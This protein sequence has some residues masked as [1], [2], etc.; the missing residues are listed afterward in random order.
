MDRCEGTSA[1][2]LAEQALCLNHFLVQCY[3]EL[4]RI[5]PRGRKSLR[6]A[7]QARKFVDECSNQALNICL[8][9]ESLSNLEK[10]QL[11]DI[12]LWAGEVY[13]LVRPSSRSVFGELLHPANPGACAWRPPS[14]DPGRRARKHDQNK[15]SFPASPAAMR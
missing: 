4:D 9:S 11:L 10:G 14:A 8:Q 5:D 15:K 1:A 12:L 2:F 6:D 7:D 3:D 13:E